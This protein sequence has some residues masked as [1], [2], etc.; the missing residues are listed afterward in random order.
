[1]SGLEPKREPFPA[2]LIV[3]LSVT[4]DVT[5]AYESVCIDEL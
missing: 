3:S 2:Q 5:G 4:E 1:V